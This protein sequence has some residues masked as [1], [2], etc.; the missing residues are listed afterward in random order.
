M[1]FSVPA[2]RPFLNKITTGSSYNY[3]SFCSSLGGSTQSSYF[4]INGTTPGL[5]YT[6]S[7]NATFLYTADIAQLISDYPGTSAS[8]Y[9][10]RGGPSC[11]NASGSGPLTS[12]TTV[13]ISNPC[14]DT[15]T[16][17]LYIYLNNA[18][19]WVNPICCVPYGQLCPYIS[20]S[21]VQAYWTFD[22]DP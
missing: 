8:Y 22:L 12:N 1:S 3:S 16:V 6:T 19:G 10:S 13:T 21:Q 5:T 4:L 17:D 2:I 15:Q 9:W 20:S 14:F 18:S 7:V 11:P